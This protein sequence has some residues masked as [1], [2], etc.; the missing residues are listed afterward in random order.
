MNEHRAYAAAMARRIEPKLSD[1][2]ARLARQWSDE[3]CRAL[4]DGELRA[5]HPDSRRPFRPGETGSLLGAIAVG[6]IALDAFNAW[7]KLHGVDIVLRPA[8]LGPEKVKYT[9]GSP[10]VIEEAKRLANIAATPY[11]DTHGA[12]PSIMWAAK[13]VQPHLNLAFGQSWSVDTIKRHTL[14]SWT[15]AYV[16][17]TAQKEQKP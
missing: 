9:S 1:R 2:Q 15:P 17:D 13:E 14:S 11:F 5:V 8:D 4:A 10:E 16:S 3:I 12:F 7:L 6:V